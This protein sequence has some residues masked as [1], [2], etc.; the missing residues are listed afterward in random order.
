MARY[1]FSMDAKRK[2]VLE[3]VHAR[4]PLPAPEDRA[5]LRRGARLR[6]KDVADLIGV[7]PTTVWNWERGL[8]E[9]KT[10]HFDAYRDVL[11]ALAERISG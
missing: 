8:C 9:P 6:L 5:A 10:K 2:Q 1:H 4:R 11:E 3:L 7:T